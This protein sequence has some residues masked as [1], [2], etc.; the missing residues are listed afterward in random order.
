MTQPSISGKEQIKE[1]MR[2]NPRPQLRRQLLQ[3]RQSTPIATRLAW[4][5]SIAEQVYTRVIAMNSQRLAVY[6]PIKGEPDLQTCYQALH[7]HGVR[8]ALPLVVGKGLALRFVP[9]APGDAMEPDDWGIPIPQQRDQELVVD[10][11]L[12]PC[13]GFNTEHY[14][15]GYGGGFYDR[16]LAQMPQANTI[17]IAYQ[18]AQVDFTHESYDIA[19]DCIVTEKG[20]I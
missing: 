11:L 2:A 5:Q 4:D 12:I 13:V 16:S 15:L 18:Q 6:W 10:T 19:M 20:I 9:W 17:G 7:Q 8:L 1:A 3:S 14:R